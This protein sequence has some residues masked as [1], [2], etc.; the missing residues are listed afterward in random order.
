MLTIIPLTISIS[1]SI[2]L[3]TNV[4]AGF[5]QGSIIMLFLFSVFCQTA[6]VTK[7]IKGCNNLREFSRTCIITFS[8]GPLFPPVI[9]G[10][11]IST[12]QSQN[13]C[14]K[15][16]YIM[17]SASLNLYSSKDLVTA[18]MV[19]LSLLKIHLSAK[20]MPLVEG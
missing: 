19:V 10:F 15:K 4:L 20:L 3:S 5:G 6:S 18:S 16:S 7:G 1:R 2:F 17:A 12:Y 8:A 13:S 14:Q 9:S 11:T